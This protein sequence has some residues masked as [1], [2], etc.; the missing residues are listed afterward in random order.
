MINFQ[1][2][3]K[4]AQT[5]KPPTKL[6]CWYFFKV[7]SYFFQGFKNYSISMFYTYT[8]CKRIKIS[9]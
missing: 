8:N 4:A 5:A 2:V 9:D 1:V 3:P 6:Y 7:M